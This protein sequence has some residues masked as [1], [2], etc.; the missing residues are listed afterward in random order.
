MT[1]QLHQLNSP[2]QIRSDAMINWATSPSPFGYDGLLSMEISSPFLQFSPISFGVHDGEHSD[3]VFSPSMFSPS[4]SKLSVTSRLLKK[5]EICIASQYQPHD[6]N[7]FDLYRGHAMQF[8]DIQRPSQI[9][10]VNNYSEP[11]P[12]NSSFS[13]STFSTAPNV[14]RDVAVVGGYDRIS[15]Q[16]EIERQLQDD[17]DG[18]FRSVFFSPEVMKSSSSASAT[19]SHL[20]HAGG[21]ADTSADHGR[22]SSYSKEPKSILR[23]HLDSDESVPPLKRKLHRSGSIDQSIS[24]SNSKKDQHLASSSPFPVSAIKLQASTGSAKNAL[25]S[26]ANLNMTVSAYTSPSVSNI[27]DENKR[28]YTDAVMVTPSQCKCKK[29]KCLKL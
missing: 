12:F 27:R 10:K 25:S 18:G 28:G 22:K 19:A 23:K 3:T 13:R 26:T 15:T 24:F 14:Q 8:G 9:T 20:G 7:D 4:K 6:V 11:Q 2:S 21:I 17:K 1:E 29:T 16:P 5:R